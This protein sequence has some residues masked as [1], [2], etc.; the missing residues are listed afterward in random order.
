[1]DFL[2]YDLYEFVQGPKRKKPTIGFIDVI[3]KVCPFFKLDIRIL[4][5]FFFMN[6]K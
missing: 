6:N 1:M 3:K 4:S 5:L 2:E